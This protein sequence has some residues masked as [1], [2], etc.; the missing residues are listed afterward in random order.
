MQTDLVKCHEIYFQ[1]LLIGLNQT[2]L[3]TTLARLLENFPP[4]E[5]DQLRKNILLIGGGSQVPGFSERLTRDL[6]RDSPSGS[7]INIRVGKGGSQ[8]AY[9]GMQYI[10]K[11]ERELLDRFS[12]KRED[13]FLKEGRYFV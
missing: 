10:A 11:Y 2:D 5:A 9:L 7:Q 4:A 6:I 13:Y 12:F 1:P 8:G 3:V